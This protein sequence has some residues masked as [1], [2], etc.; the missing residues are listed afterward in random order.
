MDTIIKYTGREI[1]QEG[2][3]IISREMIIQSMDIITL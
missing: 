1:K 2:I 3:E